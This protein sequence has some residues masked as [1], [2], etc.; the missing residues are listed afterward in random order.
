MGW[1]EETEAKKAEKKGAVKPKSVSI[2][3][4][5]K[6]CED[7]IVLLE[8]SIDKGNEKL[9]LLPPSQVKEIQEQL[10]L[11]A[12][13]QAELDSHYDLLSELYQQT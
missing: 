12:K 11:I 7:R 3:S 5:I 1:Q 2:E 4:Q 13:T 10:A 9:T 6:K 8:E